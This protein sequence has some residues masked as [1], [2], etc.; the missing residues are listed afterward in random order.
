M[1]A[2]SLAASGPS[3][4]SNVS[5]LPKARPPETT[6][7]AEPSS[8]RSEICASSE[9]RRESVVS[10]GLSVMVVTPAS[11]VGGKAEARTVTMRLASADCTVSMALPA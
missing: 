11:E 3:R 4:A 8:G 10:A 5:L 1:A 2:S 9:T 7:F 6:I